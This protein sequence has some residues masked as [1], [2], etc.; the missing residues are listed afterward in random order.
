MSTEKLKDARR[1]VHWPGHMETDYIY[2][3]GLAGEKFFMEMKNSG[4]I[5]AA[6]CKH[7]GFI[8]LPP[9][10][11]C[12]RCFKK[13]TEWVNVGTKGEVFSYTVA[14]VDVDSSRLKEPTVYAYIKFDGA[15]GGLIHR[16][17]EVEPD[18]VQIGMLVE[19][20]F[21]PLEERNADINDIK[22]FKPLQ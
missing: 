18:D 17:G 19:A 1:I 20:V 21:K 16:L 8:Y 22:Y 4:R 13:L 5:F 11:Y 2:T 14:Y 12:E 9:R 10:L 7:C 3:L 6:K 15:H